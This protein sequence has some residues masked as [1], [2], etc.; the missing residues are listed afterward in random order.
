M[1]TKGFFA[2]LF[3]VSFTSFIT[4]KIIK[5]IY[6]LTLALLGVGYVV[7][8]LAAFDQSA[9]FG[10]LML[11]LIGPLV[12]LLYAI[13]SRVLLEFIMAVF[14]IMET[15]TEL[16]FLARA[17]GAPNAP[18]AAAIPRTPPPGATISDDGAYWWDGTTW[19]PVPG[20]SSQGRTVIDPDGPDAPTDRP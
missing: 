10:V 12:F 8:V 17:Q 14:R 18:A 13:Y 19:R 4:T 5:F 9:G 3:D 20:A 1:P 11:V 6:V 16:V 2:S 7:V 15:N